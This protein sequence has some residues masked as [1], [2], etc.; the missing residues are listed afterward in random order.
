ML[1]DAYKIDKFFI[2]IQELI[3][4]M[5][6]QLAQIG[7]VVQVKATDNSSQVRRRGRRPQ[8]EEY[9]GQSARRKAVSPSL[10]RRHF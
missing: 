4:E 1:R 8:I 6:A 5:D 9:T 7:S 3:S 2:G 10:F